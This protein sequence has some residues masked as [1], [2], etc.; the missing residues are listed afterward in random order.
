MEKVAEQQ[1]GRAVGNGVG[2]QGDGSSGGVAVVSV[3]S[4]ESVK[5]CTLR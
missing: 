1:S 2:E 4:I 5:V 3:Q